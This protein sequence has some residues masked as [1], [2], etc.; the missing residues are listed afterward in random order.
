MSCV[1]ECQRH[2]PQPPP[3]KWLVYYHKS[4]SINTILWFYYIYILVYNITT[5]NCSCNH[6]LYIV[7][8]ILGSK[9]ELYFEKYLS[10]QN[11]ISILGN[12]TIY[13]FLNKQ[14]LAFLLIHLLQYPQVYLIFKSFWKPVII[15]FRCI[16]ISIFW[17]I[18]T[19]KN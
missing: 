18:S 4:R 11:L 13:S 14:Q 12:H 8:W 19:I 16:C 7:A 6:E 5:F 10:L 15:L 9:E 2:C 17:S 1:T 3:Q